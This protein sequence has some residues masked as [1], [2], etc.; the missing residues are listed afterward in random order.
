LTTTATLHISPLTPTDA[1]ELLTFI[2]HLQRDDPLRPV[3]VVAPSNYALLSLRH[4]L[5]RSGFANVQF[6]VFPR[7]AELLGA[8]SLSAQGRRPLTSIFDSAVVRDVASEAKGILEPLRDHPSTHMSLRQTF[9]QLR[10]ATDAALDNLAAQDGL[11]AETVALFRRYRERIRDYYDDEDLAE[12]AAAAVRNDNAPGLKDLGFIVFFRVRGLTP[13]QRTLAHALAENG[14]CAMLLGETGDEQADQST[15]ALADDLRPV[16]SEP[17]T[18]ADAQSN[19]PTESPHILIAPDAHQELRWVIRRIMQRAESGTPFHR[20]AVLYRKEAPYGTLIREELTLANIPVA[21][22]NPASLADTAVGSTLLGLLSLRDADFARDAVMAW[23]TGCPLKPPPGIDTA[24]FNPTLW[25]TVSKRAN[26][27]RGSVQWEQRLSQYADNLDREATDRQGELSEARAERM[28]SD[29]AIARQLLHFVTDLIQNA[30]P[31]VDHSWS[32]YSDWAKELLGSYLADNLPESEQR[33]YDRIERVLNELKSADEI[34]RDVTFEIFRRALNEALQ[35]SVGHLGSVGHGV[36]VAP[37][38]PAAAMSF[39]AVHIVGMIEGAVPP[40]VRDDPLI[41]ERDRERAGGAAAGLPLQQQRKDDERYDYL[42]ALATAPE[43]TLS[44][45]VADPAGQ[46]GNYPSRWLLERASQLEGIPVFASTL[47]QLGGR[48]WMTIITSMRHSLTTTHTSAHA[49]THDYNMDRLQTWN[50]AGLRADLH[51]LTEDTLLASAFSLSAARQGRNFTEWDGNLSAAGANFAGILGNRPLSPT[52][53]ERWAKCP[54]SYFLGTILRL[55]AEDRPED[56]YAITP[57]ER[58]SLVHDI[59]EKFINTA[60]AQNSL[61]APSE[62]W[63]EDHHRELR[64]I[65]NEHFE[66]AEARGVTGKSVMWQIA[67]DEILIDLD[68]FLDA[69]L[70]M[71]QQ[72]GVSPIGVEAEFGMSSE[73]WDPAAYTLSDNSQ[74]S[75]RGKIDRVDADNDH[76]KV[77]VLDYKTG[78]D[79]SY[80]KLK[81]DPIDRGHH[82]QLAIYALAAR[83]ALGAHTLGKYPAVSAAYW[84]VTGRG[85]FALLPSSPVSIGNDDVAARFEDGISTIVGGIRQGLFPAN[86]GDPDRG[87]FANCRFCDFKSLCPSR[88]DVQWRRKS[89][90]S[91][92]SE[93]VRLTDGE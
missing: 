74:V 28:R 13:A 49:D 32:G 7:L 83:Q 59:L 80:R 25:D 38:K 36:F 87:S 17:Q 11:R 29:A 91:A 51:P 42:A 70:R 89:Q 44:Y 60:R 72:F 12:A 69:D 64:R 78:S 5:G 81:D 40:A 19:A 43:H 4:R 53:L 18:P 30:S 90:A 39:D 52:S 47:P 35:A 58:G 56:I 50:T 22:P 92:L 26:V 27:V 24:S 6:M 63:S 3:T 15:H 20:M 16:L 82:L 33:T 79:Y 61:P 65:A 75:F 86:P 9:R 10:H 2:R 73:G 68:S 46:R 55:S 54:F 57:I 8:P 23:L 41:P 34:S 37:L 84:F 48:P 85:N 93:Y 76:S 21:G 88:R 77:L 45:P 14:R 66:E 31:P 67:R 62:A 71:R 1:D